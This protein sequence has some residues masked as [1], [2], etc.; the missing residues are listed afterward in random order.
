MGRPP[1][2]AELL[3]GGASDF[4]TFYRRH[5]SIVDAYVARRA[6]SRE[7][8]LD[9]V[10]E[11]FARALAARATFDPERGP[12]IAWLLGIARN[13]LIDAARR[14]RVA[15]RTRRKLQMEPVLVLDESHES[16]GELPTELLDAALA[17]LP[18][19]QRAAVL[20]RIVNEEPYG[21]IAERTQCS[22]QVIRKRVSRGLA[23]ARRVMEE[24][25]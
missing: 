2:D 14:G 7:L 8:T 22:E 23:A 13:Q 19:E 3:R 1:T 16:A 21:L 17:A 24:Q 18:E 20:A 11:T 25:A 5:L 10:A 6:R 12:A 4:E 9:I 15:D